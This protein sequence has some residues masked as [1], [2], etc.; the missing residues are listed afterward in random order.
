M[1]RPRSIAFE[2]VIYTKHWGVGGA[3]EMFE[4]LSLRM[5]RAEPAITVINVW[6]EVWLI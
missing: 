4:G 3:L 2:I 6:T 1:G 5:T